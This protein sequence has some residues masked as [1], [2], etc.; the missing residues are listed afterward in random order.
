MAKQQLVPS[1]P[2]S[3]VRADTSIAECVRIM[4]DS[5][6]GA[7]V[8]LSDNTK[9]EIVG[10][11]TERDL[12]RHI[13]LIQNGSA[14]HRPVRMVMTTTV[15]TVSADAIDEAPKIMAR[16]KIRHLPVIAEERGRKRL[17]GVISMR[18]VFRFMMEAADYSLEKVFKAVAEDE[19]PLTKTIGVVSADKA[20]TALVESGAELIHHLIIKAVPLKKEGFV[21]QAA[22]FDAVLLDIEDMEAEEWLKILGQNRGKKLLIVL[23]DPFSLSQEQRAELQSL[24][25]EKR[26]HLMPKPLA[27]GSFYEKFLKASS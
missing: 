27:L 13:E 23:F 14:W 2:V 16:Y 5:K 25:V 26:F 6:I 22:E 15:R 20:L 3:A 21:S 7:L 18:D 11:F 8:I 12:V 24:A 17:V 10:I 1:T 9:E 4:R 19:P